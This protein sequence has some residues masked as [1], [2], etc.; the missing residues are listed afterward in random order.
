MKYDAHP[1]QSYPPGF[2]AHAPAPRKRAKW[3]WILGGVFLAGLIG[4]VGIFAFALGGV[5]AAIDKLGSDSQG[6]DAVAGHMNEPIADGKFEF[7]VTGVKCAL[8][9][10][11]DGQLSQQAQGQYCLVD[12]SVKNVGTSA[13]VFSDI[14]QTAYDT[15]GNQYSADSGAAVYAN[16]KNAT[17][18]AQIN[19]GN[20][21]TGK[22]VFDVPTGTRLQSIVL[23]ESMFSAGVK[24]PLK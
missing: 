2:P 11:G 7:T 16:P 8:E 12:V 22:L 15:S 4:C 5:G 14:A 13:E 24:I 21:V 19:P 18:I 17:F 23:H 1:Q 9:K 6:G 3:P 20:A 10:V